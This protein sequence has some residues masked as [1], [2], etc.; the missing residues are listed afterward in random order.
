[1]TV[2]SPISSPIAIDIFFVALSVTGAGSTAAGAALA[3]APLASLRVLVLLVLSLPELENSVHMASA[4]LPMPQVAI[5]PS[6]EGSRI[7]HLNFVPPF[8][9][10]VY[11]VPL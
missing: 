8:V 5:L 3:D 10:T 6:F 2:K 11:C 1:V 7:S 9:M 4:P